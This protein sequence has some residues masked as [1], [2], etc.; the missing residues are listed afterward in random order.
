[1]LAR[2]R[3]RPRRA[4]D[5]NV[6]RFRGGDRRGCDDRAGG[7]GDLRR[8]AYRPPVIWFRRAWYSSGVM[9]PRA[10]AASSS[11]SCCSIVGPAAP[12]PCWATNADCDVATPALDSHPLTTANAAGAVR[13]STPKYATWRM[14]RC[15]RRRMSSTLLPNIDISATSVAATGSHRM[16]TAVAIGAKPWNG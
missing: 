16:R 10:H 9:P 2:A 11:A 13:T 6:R 14:R 15:G 1:G 7:D 3:P 4:V 5:G 12:P 8:A